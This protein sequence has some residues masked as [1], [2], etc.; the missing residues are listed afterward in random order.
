MHFVKVK[1]YVWLSVISCSLFFNVCYPM[2]EYAR[3]KGFVYLHEIDPTIVVSPRYYGNENFVGRAIDGYKEPVIILTRRAAEAL[4]KVQ[5]VVKKD[6]YCLVVYD[7]Y[8][9]QQAVNDFVR[10]GENSGDQLNELCYYPRVKKT[11]LFDCYISR[12]S[13]HSRGSTV[14]LTIIKCDKSL[15]AVEIK[16]RQLLDGYIIKFLDDGTVDMGSSFD[17]FDIVSHSHNDLIK[18]KYKKRRAYLK[19]VMKSAGFKN[20]CNEWWHFTLKNEP[21]SADQDSSYF[22]FPVA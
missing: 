13:G 19:S 17:L 7:A 14:D 11:Q 9:P 5:E 18:E 20:Y 3:D 21:F 6:G 4:K 15:H 12:R 16:D 2:P 10:W 1:K 8:R 22:D